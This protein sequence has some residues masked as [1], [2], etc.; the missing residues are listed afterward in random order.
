VAPFDNAVAVER[1]LLDLRTS[2]G[3]SGSP[4]FRPADGMVIGIHDAGIEATTA[5][6]IPLSQ[7]LVDQVLLFHDRT[8][9]GTKREFSVQ[10][11]RRARSGGDVLM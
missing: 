1:L 3:M 2:V 5:F 10:A 4:V 6:A 11:V 8:E 9:I 7:T